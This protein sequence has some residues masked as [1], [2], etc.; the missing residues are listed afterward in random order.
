MLKAIF[1]RR[2]GILC[3]F[4][5]SGHAG[6]GFEGNDMVCAAVSS[7]VMLVCNA[8]TDSFKAAASV[9]VGEN[10]ISLRLKERSDAAEKLLDAFLAHM[11]SIADDY[12]KVKVETRNTGGKNDD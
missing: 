2:G 4:D 6:Y 1:Y 11:E 9:E 3:G 12:S 8:V 7:A 10:L 5:I